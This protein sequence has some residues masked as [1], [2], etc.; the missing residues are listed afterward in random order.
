MSIQRQRK[1]ASSKSERAVA[2][3]LGGR[4]TPGSGTGLEKADGR[5]RGEFRIENKI[6]AKDSYRLTHGD[7]LKLWTAAS[8]AG[9]LPVFHIKMK[10]SILG[11]TE[12]VVIPA[13]AAPY[14]SMRYLTQ[15]KTRGF[16]LHSTYFDRHADRQ[17]R[18]T[19]TGP[20]QGEVQDFDLVALNYASFLAFV[21]ENRTP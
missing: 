21:E 4:V 10:S 18:F 16:V 5:V 14:S 9:E 1:R 2:A 12:I 7:W 17:D 19:L 8:A 15:R 3:R 6:T 11:H 13:D 20:Y